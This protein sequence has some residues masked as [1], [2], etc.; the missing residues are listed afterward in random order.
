SGQVSL[1]QLTLAG[2]AAFLLSPI[3][4]DWGVPFP[5]APVLAA[6]GATVIGV[7]IGLTALRIRG[8]PVA[9]VTLSLAVAVQAL[10]FQHVDLV[11]SSGKA[12]ASPSLFGVDLGPGSGA[13]YPRPQFC[14]M[15]LGILVLTALAVAALRRSRLG[16]AML[17]V[18][19]N[20]RSAAASGV[21]VVA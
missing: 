2:V 9:I 14:L 3:A 19:A 6:L 13:A 7:V 1:A 21:N 16:G 20:E 5:L 10:W 18:R 15:V 4:G 17:A 12:I 8:L 11:G